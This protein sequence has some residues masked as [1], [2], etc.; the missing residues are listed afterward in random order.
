VNDRIGIHVLITN[1]ALT[2][3]VSLQPINTLRRVTGS[4]RS[5]Q[6]RSIHVMCSQ[7]ALLYTVSN[8]VLVR[9]IGNESVPIQLAQCRFPGLAISNAKILIH[10]SNKIYGSNFIRHHLEAVM[11]WNYQ[12][13]DCVL[14]KIFFLSFNIT[15]GTLSFRAYSKRVFRT[16]CALRIKKCAPRISSG[17]YF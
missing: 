4:T 9:D 8:W 12:N 16:K 13:A 2:V 14:R 15:F 7:Q 1:R 3:L 17:I 10:F 5:D 6:F 11:V